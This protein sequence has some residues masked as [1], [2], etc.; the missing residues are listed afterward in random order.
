MIF[1]KN[2]VKVLLASN[3]KLA[4]F[5]YFFAKIVMLT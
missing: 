1:I 2:I 4:T 5:C 3:R